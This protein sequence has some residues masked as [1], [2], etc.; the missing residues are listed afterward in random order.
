MNATGSGD[1]NNGRYFGFGDLRAD[2]MRCVISSGDAQA[3]LEPKVTDLLV[4]SRTRHAPDEGQTRD[5]PIDAVWR[6]EHGRG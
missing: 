1:Q 2:P 4:N 3:R 6:I 5:A